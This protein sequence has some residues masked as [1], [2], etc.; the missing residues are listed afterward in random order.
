MLMNMQVYSWVLAEVT[1]L[2]VRYLVTMCRITV[3]PVHSSNS[4][5]RWQAWYVS[6]CAL[7][8]VGLPVCLGLHATESTCLCNLCDNPQLPIS[9]CVMERT[10]STVKK[11]P[12]A[13]QLQDM[14]C[15]YTCCLKLNSDRCVLGVWYCNGAD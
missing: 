14:C 2:E 15:S 9:T 3:L 12:D 1:E 10:Q 13:I 7:F 4:L 8:V 11:L 6:S 5:A